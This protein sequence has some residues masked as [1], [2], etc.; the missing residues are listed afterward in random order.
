MNLN[1]GISS[2]KWH[3][4][5][6]IFETFYALLFLSLLIYLLSRAYASVN[7]YRTRFV[8]KTF[9]LLYSPSLVVHSFSNTQQINFSDRLDILSTVF[10]SSY[11][12]AQD[13]EK[14]LT[15]IRQMD[16][17]NVVW[18]LKFWTIVRVT[19]RVKLN[20]H[21]WNLWTNIVKCF[22]QTNKY[23]L[24]SREIFILVYQTAYF[25]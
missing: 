17:S 14:L 19:Q 10:I 5:L 20:F 22:P 21:P 11:S 13:N 2:V 12:R 1:L 24:T 23:I 15:N 8:C 3:E 9:S 16:P 6:L 7:S 4:S 18:E 25:F